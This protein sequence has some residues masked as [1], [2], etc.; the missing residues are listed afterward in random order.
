MHLIF[1]TPYK[2]TYS[3]EYCSLATFLGFIF[4]LIA[5][6]LPF[7]AA[8]S[9][10]DFWLRLKEYLE[11]PNIEFTGNYMIYITTFNNNVIDN[12]YF[13]SSSNDLNSKYGDICAYNQR[14]FNIDGHYQC[15]LD[16]N[17]PIFTRDDGKLNINYQIDNNNIRNAVK[18]EIKLII[19]LKY[20]L[21]K[22][23]KLIMTPL[24]YID[25]PNIPILSLGDRHITLEGDLELVQK[26]PIPYTSITSQIYYEEKPLN[27]DE[28]LYS[29]FDFS[30]YFEKYKNLNYTLKYNYE[31]IEKNSENN[32]LI[33]DI[34]MNIPKLQR[35]FYIES[36]YE[37]IKYAWMQYFYLFLP[38]YI[39]LY[40]I[41]KFIIE[42]NIFYSHVKSDL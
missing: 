36:V 6:L 34:N 21:T 28:K 19:F 24:V 37:A 13:Y 39:I 8:I 12:N 3:S 22:K 35:V 25:I 38:I 4:L 15:D 27:I 31:K 1:L 29:H 5:I 26:S 16:N 17:Q 33:I 42:N 32:N 7:F 10:E 9:S 11:Q 30:Y 23:I 40:M 20:Y 2:K 14:I 41:Y 18:K